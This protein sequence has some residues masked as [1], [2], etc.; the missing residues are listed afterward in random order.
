MRETQNYKLTLTENLHETSIFF[1]RSQNDASKSGAAT[2]S[3]KIRSPW[4]ITLA[5]W[6][7]T[8][9]CSWFTAAFRLYKQRRWGSNMGCDAKQKGWCWEEGYNLLPKCKIANVHVQL[10]C[11][12]FP[13]P[14]LMSRIWVLRGLPWPYSQCCEF[15]VIML[16]S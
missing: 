9:I 11:Y 3:I 8:R 12:S 1:N 7:T 13:A 14:S 10:I 6:I 2:K 4:D 16:P 15:P 5:L